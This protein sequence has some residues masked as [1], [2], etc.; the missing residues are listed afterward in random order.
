MYG[1]RQRE[2]ACSCSEATPINVSHRT[3]KSLSKFCME[4]VPRKDKTMREGALDSA[5]HP[6]STCRVWEFLHPQEAGVGGHMLED[7]D[8]CSQG[9]D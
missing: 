3:W 2:V 1:H 4:A 7:R 8:I 9:C 5:P 6:T